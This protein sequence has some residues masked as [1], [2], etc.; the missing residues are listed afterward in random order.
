MDPTLLASLR[1]A[2][3]QVLPAVRELRHRLHQQPEIA[4]KEERTRATLAAA[5][6]GAPLAVRPPLLGTDL[7]ADLDAGQTQTICLRA[8][9]D[10]LPILEESGVAHASRVPGMMH[11]C[12]HDGHSAMLAGAALVL[13]RLRAKLPANVR[14]IFQPGEE[15]VAAG[16]QLIAAGAAN[17]CAAAYALHGWPGLPKGVFSAPVGTAFAAADFFDLV[18]TGRGGH[19]A[20][21]ERAISPIVAGARVVTALADLHREMKERH[22]AVVTVATI[23]AGE[24]L[25]IIP[26]RLKLA[27]T[28][29]F[30]QRGLGAEIQ[31]AMERTIAAACAGT[32]VTWQLDYRQ[33]YSEP[34]VNAPAA[35]AQARRLVQQAYGPAG[36]RDAA[37][38]TMGAE[39]FAYYLVDRPGA[40]LWLGL[41]EQ[42][43]PLHH[44]RFDFNDAALGHGITALC[45]LALGH[46]PLAR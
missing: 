4:L 10:A 46:E 5:L 11:A 16:R 45:L 41:G 20:M 9:I 19:A 37:E 7:I 13:V 26:E 1:D 33:V 6:T 3:D 22:R 2:V 8:D 38:P 21:P 31:A 43:P 36:W 40:M 28:T 39:D 27:G 34:V 24:A 30:L 32:G 25:N 29:R 23:H 35:V 12:G 18:L 44:P 15:N 42:S 14:F 17:G